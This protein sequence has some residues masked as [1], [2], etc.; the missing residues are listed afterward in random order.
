MVSQLSEDKTLE[1]LAEEM[2]AIGGD[3]EALIGEDIRAS[4]RELQ[5][6]MSYL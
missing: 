2:Q 1:M 4:C 3:Q 5:Q 6:R